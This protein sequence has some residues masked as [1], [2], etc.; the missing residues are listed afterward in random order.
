MFA[1]IGSY[2]V[3]VMNQANKS[4]KCLQIA[5]GA[6]Y[7]DDQKNWETIHDAKIDGLESVINEFSGDADPAGV[8]V[9]ADADSIAS[10]LRQTSDCSR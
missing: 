8:L 2:D 3:E 4:M 1:E 7:V 10:T 6:C 5:S 9:E